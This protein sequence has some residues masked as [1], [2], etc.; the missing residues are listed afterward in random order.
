M[1]IKKLVRKVFGKLAGVNKV[2]E[3]VD[4]AFFFLNH[5]CDIR[6]FPQATGSL[7][8]LQKCDTLLLQILDRVCKKH[9]LQ[10]W[11]DSGTLLGAVRHK[12]F[13]PWDDDVDVCMLRSDYERALPILNA[14]LGKYGIVAEESAC[15]QACRIGVAYKHANTG[16]WID[17]LPFELI[18]QEVSSPAA[19]N[20]IISKMQ[21]Y[22]KVYQRK[23]DRKYLSREQVFALQRKIIPEI[24]SQDEAKAVIYSLKFSAK[25]RV[26]QFEDIFPLKMGRFEDCELPIPHNVDAYLEQF[27]GKNYMSFP[28]SGLTHHGNKE[29]KLYTWAEKSGT[30]MD[31]VLDELR[32]ILSELQ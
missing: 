2:Q 16:L 32:A 26:Y 20:R 29:G 11:L 6:S 1:S 21:K 17:I 3:Q 9:G 15:S 8:Q 7:G 19:R 27:Y 12:G 10:Y 31:R 14:E 13:I 5:Y 25:C 30:D 24:C 23:N 4:T 22:K 18:N 28:Q